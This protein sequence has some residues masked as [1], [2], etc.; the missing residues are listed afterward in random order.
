MYQIL[1]TY[2]Y[3]IVFAAVLAE[4][5]GLPIPSFLVILFAAAMGAQGRFT[6]AGLFIVSLA[7]ALMGD[8][9]WYGLGR[10]RGR[11][12]LRTLCSLSLNP[13]SC[14][15]RTENLFERHGLKSLLVAKFLP[16]LNTIGAPLAGMLK[17]SPIRFGLFDLG[18]AGL[19]AGAALA[20]GVA[21]R[22]ELDWLSAWLLAF[23]RTG[24]LILVSLFIGWI[25]LKW[26]ERRRFYQLLER[27]RVTATE[28]KELIDKGE[29]PV[30]VDLRSSL[31]LSAEGLKIPGAIHIPPHEF[32]RRHHEIPAGRPVVMVC[33]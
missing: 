24:G 31:S 13:D 1:Q 4:N 33:T 14:V 9:V 32:S 2:G 12:I 20:L 19:W 3:P 26:V 27:S 6:I 21:F 22:L 8:F 30:V 23:G 5:L 11:P 17:L 28:L 16:G 18:G 25:A 29:A 7:A 15:S 10:V